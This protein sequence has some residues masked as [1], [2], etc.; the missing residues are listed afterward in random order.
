MI[1]DVGAHRGETAVRYRTLFPAAVIHSFEPSPESFR[2]LAAVA[3]STTGIEP[4][5]LALS[6][7]AGTAMLNVNRSAAT[8]SLLPSAATGRHYW[9]EGLLDTQERVEVRTQTL[10]GFCA[11]RGIGAIDVLKL[12]VQGAEHAVLRGASRLLGGAAIDVIYMELIIAPT[13]VG[14][15]TL[16]EYLE[17]FAEHRYELFDLY[18]PVRRRERLIQADALIVSATCLARY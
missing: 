5:C 16:H 4:H 2:A 13:Y 6:D 11:E 9:G 17:L 18:N 8:S 7:A 3:A 12:D 1:F 10:D 15:R 14:Q